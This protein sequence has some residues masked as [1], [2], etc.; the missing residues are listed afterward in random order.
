MIQQVLNRQLLHDV[1]KSMQTEAKAALEGQRRSMTRT[2]M[3]DMSS[4][5]RAELL[6]DIETATKHVSEGL[7]AKGNLDLGLI[8]RLLKERS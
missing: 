6:A 3:D 7:E 8:E 5:A 4:E 2:P 1:L